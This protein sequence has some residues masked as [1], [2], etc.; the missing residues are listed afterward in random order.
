MTTLTSLVLSQNE[1]IGEFF[2]VMNPIQQKKEINK[3]LKLCIPRKLYYSICKI[4]EFVDDKEILDKDYHDLYY[5]KI[6]KLDFKINDLN[7]V[8]V[9]AAWHNNHKLLKK[10]CLMVDMNTYL[11]SMASHNCDMKSLLIMDPCVTNIYDYYNCAQFSKNEKLR[12]DLIDYVKK[13]SRK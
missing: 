13:N 10:L 2:K 12:L 5:A 7:S 4:L 11:V 8:V 9:V 1:N 6:G 3:I